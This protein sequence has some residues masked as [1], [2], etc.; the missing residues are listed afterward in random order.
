MITDRA[1]QLRHCA[2]LFCG[3]GDISEHKKIENGL[4]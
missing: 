2:Q 1:D 4:Y 3:D